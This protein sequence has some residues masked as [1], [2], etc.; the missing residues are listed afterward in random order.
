MINCVKNTIFRYLLF[1]IVFLIPILISAATPINLDGPTLLPKAQLYIATSDSDIPIGSTFEV[2]IYINTQG[3]SINTVNVDLKFNPTEISVVKPST[4]DSIFGIW[5]ENPSYDNQNGTISITGIIPNGIITTNGLI[6]TVTFKALALGDT[7]INITDYSSANLNDG[8]GSS[9][10]LSLDDA[11]YNIIPSIET[12]CVL[13]P[14]DPTCISPTFC[15]LNPTD[16]TCQT[17]TETFCMLH[18]TDPACVAPLPYCT[19]HP[20]DPLCMIPDS[21]CSLHPTDPACVAPLPYCTVHPTDP[22]CVVPSENINQPIVSEKVNFLSKEIENTVNTVAQIKEKTS[23]I[24]N[25][26]EGKTTS[27]V[28]ATVGAISGASISIA[29]VMFAN[30]LSFWELFL[31]PVRLWSLVLIAFGLKKRNV[32]WGTVY[33]SVTKQPLDPAYVVLQ[34][35]MGNEVATSIT[36]LDGRYG[37]LV[38]AGQYKMIA[39][40]TNYIFPS[41]KLLNKKEDEL[42]KDLYFSEII[43]VPEGGVITKNIPMD[44]LKFDWNEFAKKDKKLMRFF[45]QRDIWISRISET[46]FFFGLTIAIIATITT[47]AIYNIAILSVYLVLF[48]LK[49]TILKPR[50]FGHIKQKG[51]KNPLS[52]A[53]V[54][55]FFD[56]SNNEIIHKVTDKTG[57]YYCLV[58]NGKYYTKIESKNPDESYSLIDTSLPIEVKNGYINKKFEV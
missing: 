54:R 55:V 47:T 23:K 51:T 18:P 11:I 49:R 17:P 46:L 9:V 42:Y 8:V 2:P 27:K 39:S 21:Y 56:G 19:I 33:D 15:T 10:I 48:I 24:L 26:P 43:D 14:T 22:G 53:V 30:P 28:V 35:L 50:A 58:P 20:T 41:N 52:F 36:D 44:P 6:T 29:T 40:K 4:G 37:F 57:K 34:D 31:I 38:P 13:H 32:P 5:F 16:P 45:S 25:T 12:F 7:T 3:K 1:L